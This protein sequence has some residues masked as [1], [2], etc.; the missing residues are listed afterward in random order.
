M[1]NLTPPLRA[2]VFDMDGLLAD[3]EPLS[4][5]SWST[6]I[7]D[8]YGVT[9]TAADEAWSA[10]TVGKS[11]GEAWELV[12]EHFQ[13][14][15]E[16]PRDLPEFS[17]KIR[18]RYHRIL[19]DGVPPMPGAIELVLACRDA[20]FRLGVASSSGMDAIKLVL[21]KLGII[22]CFD[23]LTSGKEV[24]KSKP[25]PAIY[26]LAC[27]RLGVSPREAV[28]IEDSGPGI[29]AAHLAGLRCLAIPSAITK[30]HDF[31]G[32]SAIRPTLVGVTP[33]TLIKLP[34]K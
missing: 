30:S 27:D 15:L 24:P 8:E 4:F 22:D 25:D 1:T 12:R 6:M 28:A 7:A 23:A 3:T 33:A 16:F 11:G 10:I 20:G 29:T 9:I 19:E 17:Q 34:W 32:A 31:S 5:Q 18:T 2:I 21:S 13:L 26:R 14:P